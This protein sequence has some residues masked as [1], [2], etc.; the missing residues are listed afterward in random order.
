MP[1]PPPDRS[2]LSIGGVAILL[3]ALLVALTFGLS[4][5]LL[6]GKLQAWADAVRQRDTTAAIAQFGQGLVDLSLER[7]VVQVTLQLPDPVAP[8]FRAMIDR[9]RDAAG[10]RLGATLAGLDRL[11]GPAADALA[12]DIRAALGRLDALRRTA[13]ADLARPRAGRDAGFVARWAEE[14]PDLISALEPRRATLRPGSD[15]IPVAISVTEQVQHLAWAVREYG[16][17]DR[18]LLAV[19]VALGQPIPAATR[20][21]MQAFH[22]MVGQ[23]LAAL[24]ALLDNQAL[25]PR[26]RAAIPALRTAYLGPYAALRDR[27]LAA[28]A[29]GRPYPVDFDAFFAESSRVL[30]LA[31][32]LSQDATVANLAYW[33]DSGWQR[34]MLM[35]ATG[36]AAL[37]GLGAGIAL[38][39]FVRTRVSAPAARLAEGIEAV[40]EGRLDAPIILRRPPAEV[41]RIAH[42]LDRLRER[43][44]QARALEQAAAR[45]RARHAQEQAATERYTAEFSAVIAGV[46]RDLSE[47]AASM[48]E[49]ARGMAALAEATRQD[50]GT[51]RGVSEASTQALGTLLGTTDALVDGTAAVTQELSAATAQVAAAVTE[52]RDSDRLMAGLAGAAAEIGGVVGTIRAI[53]AQTNLLALNATIEAARAGEAGKGFA[54]VAG[55]VKALAA[56]TARATEEVG[57]RIEAV[58]RSTEA[59]A[60]SIGRI[61]T[62]VDAVR[63]A[64][65][66][67][68]T[69]VAGQREA[70]GRIAAGLHDVAGRTEAVAG[71]MDGLTQAAEAGSDA[72]ATLL[73]AADGV[74]HRAG[75]LHDEVQA[76]LRRFEKAGERRAFK[77]HDCRV[78]VGINWDG[79]RLVATSVNLSR[80]GILLDRRLDLPT[81]REVGV[82][83]PGAPPIRARAGREAEAGT[84]LLFLAEP[85]N[86]A[87]LDLA[88]APLGLEQQHTAEGPR[89]AA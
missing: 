29:E 18:T 14:V 50:A 31:A 6:A 8:S 45:D 75:S 4:G 22:A 17:R 73:T 89:A 12:R 5:T 85:A 25:G 35:L 66:A 56:Q 46:L 59:A 70:V 83:F 48:G 84:V 88:F 10:Q 71:R 61:A 30:D 67:I 28:S 86:E 21:R 58:R 47:A 52:A 79:T 39:W 57:S 24:A 77:R 38:L 55:E 2:R 13:D 16:G 64:A 27:I 11:G 62:A 65:E 63:G 19:A 74:R 76:F 80:S 51:A 40:A 81:G 20:D 36:M 78:P 7:S 26:F 54:V 32:T 23:R 43:L 49:N 15:A 68:A 1:Q 82:E 33:Q 69:S 41:A 44:Q 53:A 9:Q 60:G 87:A 37:L 3:S 72:S 34:L 42:A